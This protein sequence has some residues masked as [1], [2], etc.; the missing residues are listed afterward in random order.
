MKKINKRVII[1]ALILVMSCSFA[2]FGAATGKA[3]VARKATDADYR[4]YNLQDISVENFKINKTGK[5]H[6]YG[7]GAENIPQK[8]DP[9]NEKWFKKA[10]TMKDQGY[11]QLCWAFSTTTAAELSYYRELV[12]NGN[13]DPVVP[14]L[15]PGHL[16]YFF[17][18]HQN[19][20][21]GNTGGDYNRMNGYWWNGGGNMVFT[22]QAMANWTGLAPE[23]VCP[24]R[25]N[26]AGYNSNLEYSNYLTQERS[27]IIPINSSNINY[28]KS[29]IQNHGAVL[30]PYC[31]GDSFDKI[32][33]NSNGETV[34]NHFCDDAEAGSNH[35]VAIIG[36][37]DTYSRKNF[38]RSNCEDRWFDTL[39]V[40]TEKCNAG[41][42]SILSLNT[43]Q[44][45]KLTV[46]DKVS[47]TS[48]TP[49]QSGV[50][51]F[52]SSS[53]EDVDPMAFLCSREDVLDYN[54]DS[55]YEDGVDFEMAY[56]LTAGT[57]Y[58]IVS[59]LYNEDS[60]DD[61]EYSINVS[62]GGVADYV[63]NVMP[64]Q[65]GAWIVQNSWGSA[66]KNYYISYED[67]SFGRIN[68]SGERYVEAIN[69]QDASD[70]KY[71]YQYDGSADYNGRHVTANQEI[72]NKFEVGSEDRTLDAIG[73]STLNEG[74]SKYTVEI[75]TNVTGTPR[76]GTSA[77][78]ISYNDVIT[79]HAGT[80]TFKLNNPVSLAK[81]TSFSIVITPKQETLFGTEDTFDN[82]WVYF[83][84]DTDYGQS[85]IR[86][87][88]GWTDL[89]SFG[90]CARIKGFANSGSTKN[91]S[92]AVITA[93]PDQTYTGNAIEP[94][95]EVKYS[96]TDLIKGR[97]YEVYFSN[98]IDSG[99][100]TALIK[101]IGNY[102]GYK[103]ATFN[104]KTVTLSSVGAAIDSIPIHKYVDRAIEPQVYVRAN[105][106]LLTR[107]VDYNL[108][109]SDNVE[110]GTATVTVQGIGNYSGTLSK[111]FTISAGSG[112]FDGKEESEAIPLETG[113]TQIFD[114]F[115]F[116]C[117]NEAY[118]SYSYKYFR[119]SIN[120]PGFYCFS[121]GTE[122]E[123]ETGYYY[124]DIFKVTEDGDEYYRSIDSAVYMEKGEYNI[125][126]CTL[127]DK[128]WY[129]LSVSRSSLQLNEW[130]DDDLYKEIEAEHGDVIDLGV[131]VTSESHN[132]ITYRW[133]IYDNDDYEWQTLNN[134]STLQ[135]KC[136][137]SD[138]NYYEI[139]CIISDGVTEITVYYDVC[140]RRYDVTLTDDGH[141][142]AVADCESARPGWVVELE[143]FPEDG[144]KFK[145]WVSS[146][147]VVDQYNEFEM[148]RKDVTI[149]ATFEPESG[150]GGGDTPGGGG[151]GGITPPPPE[152][153]AAKDE[154]VIA[155]P[156]VS[157]VDGKLTGEI[158]TELTAKIV[159]A[160]K[161]NSGQEI[162]ITVDA[163]SAKDVRES[164]IKI[165]NAVIENIAI[166][167]SVV[168]LETPNGRITLNPETA[169]QIVSKSGERPVTVNISENRNIKT[170]TYA[171]YD[172]TMTYGSNSKIANFGDGRLIVTLPIPSGINIYDG[173]SALWLDGVYATDMNAEV[174]RTNKTIAID[175]N[176]LSKFAVLSTKDAETKIVS[177]VKKSTV[178]TLKVKAL[179]GKKMKLTWK[180]GK[181]NTPDGYVVYRS[182]KNKS[183]FKKI[184]T[185]EAG[186]KS[187]TVK[188]GLKKG[189]K[190]YYKVKGYVTINDQKVYTKYSSV[191]NAKCK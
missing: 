101:G 33:K 44:T 172:I 86:N 42:V 144:Y 85:Y 112:V 51:T 95:I 117:W 54:D 174:N 36:W 139:R 171:E 99:V 98:N 154:L 77:E 12:E 39:A 23:A 14:M 6:I 110:P 180:T 64:E 150:G 73:F 186:K 62:K 90:E 71:N 67:K 83:N 59:S 70:Y 162:V 137:F 115:D 126:I 80:Y 24:L 113:S 133:E 121:V 78:T 181:G 68:S 130:D 96:S 60:I 135:Y 27:E 103:I 76:N 25:L 20:P 47:V 19:D 69:M 107:R 184:A 34:Y 49:S 50:Y 118:G 22:S 48:F 159:E 122:D 57:T 11:T 61:T 157:T 108:T 74:V 155:A 3:T 129:H 124:H 166:R 123:D 141:G 182:A 37:D 35:Q 65:D 104:I 148:P 81:G 106:A 149:K 160:I 131:N 127:D 88:S 16:G 128:N 132:T 125:A 2:V 75:F 146:D 136:D 56:R 165:P 168:T 111:T 55:D 169:Q 116:D 13:A 87:G 188:S 52:K 138:I 191:K 45:V 170:S 91:I 190:Y 177:S 142:Y 92:N 15:S 46:D 153:P 151:G 176:H 134:K 82:G 79:N 58:Y 163:G 156:Y 40:L 178:G 31:A 140:E 21:L 189:K 94:N 161:K 32:T 53:G 120:N 187:Y 1:T 63:Y 29:T 17:Y 173:V 9:R 5:N 102:S 114:A 143:A 41:K 158:S 152:E 66:Y 30:A 119:L 10:T 183:G 26:P 185:V 28:I 84:A 72:A 109:F 8:Y 145:A 43:P 147:V 38:K 175:T 97:D 105:G 18:N 167:N 7:N 93:I 4:K 89:A 100:A 164:H 179:S